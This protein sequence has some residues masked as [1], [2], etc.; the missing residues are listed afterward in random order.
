MRIQLNKLYHHQNPHNVRVV[1]QVRDLCVHLKHSSGSF[2]AIGDRILT[3]PQRF[4][5]IVTLPDAEI[6]MVQLDHVLAVNGAMIS[7]GTLTD[8]TNYVNMSNFEW[9][10]SHEYWKPKFTSGD[11]ITLQMLTIKSETSKLIS[12]PR[13]VPQKVS[14]PSEKGRATP[15]SIEMSKI[16]LFFL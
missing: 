5:R 1:Y 4:G 2:L 13:T 6:A 10:S 9:D 14:E 7:T 8:H 12:S 3:A 15:K 16:Y 11:K